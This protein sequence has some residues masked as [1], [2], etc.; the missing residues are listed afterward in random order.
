VESFDRWQAGETVIVQEV[1]RGKL[2]SARPMA[3]VEDRGDFVALWYPKGTKF[4]VAT[5]PPSR[6]RAPARLERF[7]ANL[8]LCDWALA[9]FECDVS[10]LWLCDMEA[11]H[12][13]IWCSW[14]DDGSHMGWYVNM[15][16]PFR[17]TKRGLQSMDLMLDI[18]VSPDGTWSWKDEDEFQMLIDQ[19]LIDAAKAQAVRDD[20]TRMIQ[21]LAMNLAPFCDPWPDWRPDP[22]WRLPELPAGWNQL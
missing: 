3:V 15:Q 13:S 6:Q 19:G 7:A 10:C 22:Y 9:W 12:H 16:E 5:T 11:A 18:I 8:S 14:R 20:A 1:W 4:R 2:W 21:D 17:R